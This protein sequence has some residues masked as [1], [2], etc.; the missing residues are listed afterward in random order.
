MNMEEADDRARLGASSVEQQLIAAVE[1]R[2]ASAPTLRSHLHAKTFSIP[3]PTTRCSR[4]MPDR[5]FYHEPEASR[6]RC[7]TTGPARGCGL[8][9]CTRSWY[10]A[11]QRRNGASGC[12][13][14]GRSARQ[15]SSMRSSASFAT[16]WK[17]ASAKPIEQ[18]RLYPIPILLRDQPGYRIG[19][20]S[21]VADARRSPS[22][23]IFRP[24][25]FTAAHRHDLPRGQRTARRPSAPRKCRSCLRAATPSRSPL[26]KELAQ[27][28]D[29]IDH[30]RRASVDDGDLLRR[31]KPL[32]LGSSCAYGATR[33]LRF[34]IH[35]GRLT[36]IWPSAQA[37][38]SRPLAPSQHG[39]RIALAADHAGYLLKDELAQWLRE[40]GHEVTDLGT[41]GP[42]SVDYPEYGAGLA[43]RR[44]V[45]PGGARNRDLRLGHRHFDRREPRTRSAAAPAST[46]RSRPRSL[47]SIMTRTSSLS[48]RG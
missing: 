35:L 18:I 9:S 34:G 43:Q 4:A 46:I 39:M 48:A 20:H 42:E 37:G 31:R 33:A 30:G 40:Q 7:A 25:D 26:D 41:N 27:R 44:R 6:T 11:C 29:S 17:S 32:A 14:P 12:R 15:A 21:D 36:T 23:S 22:N 3:G 19:I 45:R 16:R 28:G 10:C 13:L 24:D 38:E 8:L 47:A 1:R 5:R 2:E